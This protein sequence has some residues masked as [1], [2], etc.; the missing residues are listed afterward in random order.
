MSP[1][2]WKNVIE[3]LVVGLMS[4]HKAP[5]LFFQAAY[6]VNTLD[7]RVLFSDSRVGTRGRIES[8]LAGSAR[9]G[10]PEKWFTEEVGLLLNDLER[11]WAALE[12]IMA[13]NLQTVSASDTDI[14]R[15]VD[16]E[17]TVVHD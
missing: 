3:M 8:L 17:T 13:E 11:Y 12:V 16:R 4:L 2:N 15:R 6:R 7:S 9:Q 14:I 10:I 1:D 5:R